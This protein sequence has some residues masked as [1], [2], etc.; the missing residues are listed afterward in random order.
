MIIYK[1]LK[2]KEIVKNPKGINNKEWRMSKIS[3]CNDFDSYFDKEKF[4]DLISGLNL[5]NIP[6]GALEN[7]TIPKFRGF[8]IVE[9]LVRFIHML[10]Q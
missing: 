9:K 8:K 1:D 6:K 4:I 7:C 3:L 5:M 2:P 10:F